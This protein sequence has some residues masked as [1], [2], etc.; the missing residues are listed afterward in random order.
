M[1]KTYKATVLEQRSPSDFLQNEEALYILKEEIEHVIRK[2]KIGKVSRSRKNTPRD[3][4][5]NQ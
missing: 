5:I 3:S 1:G 2:I 4:K